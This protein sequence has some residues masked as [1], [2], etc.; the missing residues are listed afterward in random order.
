MN[1]ERQ[2]RRPMK[3]E[4]CLFDE[5]AANEPQSFYNG[6]APSFVPVPLVPSSPPVLMRCD[7]PHVRLVLS[8]LVNEHVPSR[9]PAVKELQ[10][11]RSRQ[12]L[13]MPEHPFAHGVSLRDQPPSKGPAPAGG[14]AAP[15]D[16]PNHRD[17]AYVGSTLSTKVVPWT[18]CALY[19]VRCPASA[20][21]G[22]TARIRNMPLPCMRACVRMVI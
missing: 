22:Q 9:P 20:L 3:R 4:G 2:T 13:T 21:L 17:S 16:A 18:I 6:G 15:P 12:P 1:R 5:P 14:C 8:W 7:R 10:P 19:V 11:P